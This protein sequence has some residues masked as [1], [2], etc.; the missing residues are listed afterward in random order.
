MST[1]LTLADFGPVVFSAN[2]R[3]CRCGHPQDE[4]A[5][6]TGECGGYQEYCAGNGDVQQDYCTCREFVLDERTKR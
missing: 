3:L 4:H 5:E 2:V 6:G 1:P